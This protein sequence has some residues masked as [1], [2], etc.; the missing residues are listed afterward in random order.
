MMTMDG[1]NWLGGIGLLT[2]V[3][4]T[5]TAFGVPR[6]AWLWALVYGLP[7]FKVG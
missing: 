4:P 2:F 6:Q 7:I 1:M 3:F 5:R